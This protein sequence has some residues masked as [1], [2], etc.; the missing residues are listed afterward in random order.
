MLELHNLL[1]VSA[2]RSSLIPVIISELFGDLRKLYS[3][4]AVF[5][6]VRICLDFAFI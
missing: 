3:S 5:V 6:V 2:L 4:E 1:E